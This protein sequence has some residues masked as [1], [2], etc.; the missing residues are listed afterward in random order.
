[1]PV[2][3]FNGLPPFPTFDDVTTKIN[4]LVQ[5]LRN[6]LLNLDTLNVSELNAEVITAGTITSDKIQ[7]GAI[8]TDK[9]DAGA[10][11]ADKINVNQLSAIAADLGTITAGLIQAVEIY[12][13]YI[14]T[15]YG[16]YPRC[17]MSS[18]DNLLAA[19]G[20]PTKYIS[21]S[22]NTSG[23]PVLNI[24]SPTIKAL[25]TL[26]ALSNTLFIGT[27]VGFGDITISSGANLKL[28]SQ[29]QTQIDS[30][31]TFYS[32]GDSQSLGSALNSLSSSISALTSAISTKATSGASTGSGGGG[33][34]LNGG[35]P[36]G[37]SLAVA[38]GGSVTWGGI[39]LP[40]H[41]HT[42]T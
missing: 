25:I 33:V 31:N 10:V 28:Q 21:I 3:T 6:L 2:P 18:A 5:E 40:S 23:Q 7:A 1:M 9:L 19:Y 20:D 36:I 38:G 34:T 29:G 27:Q 8:T 42:Q 15:G 30:W 13:S 12:G 11:T 24:I 37:T 26:L 32:T 14:A 41:S 39:T 35:I 17:E 4:K 16:S 22:P